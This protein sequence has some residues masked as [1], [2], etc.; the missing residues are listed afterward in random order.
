MTCAPA[1][2]ACS[3]EQLGETLTSFNINDFFTTSL[4]TLVGVVFGALITILISRHEAK[5]RRQL[6]DEE[7][8]ER[9][10]ERFEEAANQLKLRNEEARERREAREEEAEFQRRL[11]DEE[12]QQHL[13]ARQA[14]IQQQR[15]IRLEDALSRVIWE[16]NSH[17]LSL[18]GL[19][20]RQQADDAVPEWAPQDWPVLAAIAMARMIARPGDEAAV[21]DAVRELVLSVRLTDVPQ[22]TKSLT[23]VWRVLI[24]WR[25]GRP[26]DEIL[27]E[28][29]ALHPVRA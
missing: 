21:L 4:A 22:R 15:L 18:R 7:A 16:I 23:E 14:E 6:R 25:G 24:V 29:A 17:S 3:L 8:A 20:E 19:W 1:D 2:L 13:E 12:A 28:I 9:R 11:R 10:A 26:A 5:Q 27:A